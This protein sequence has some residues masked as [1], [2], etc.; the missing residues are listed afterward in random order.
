MGKKIPFSFLFFLLAFYGKGQTNMTLDRDFLLPYQ[1]DFNNKNCTVFTSV[2][3]YDKE[4]IEAAIQHDSSAKYKEYIFKKKDHLFSGG[5][6]TATI[7]PLA[8][9]SGGYDMYGKSS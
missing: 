7:H 9:G 2:M 4:K 1:S 8:G 5:A 3:P 6:L